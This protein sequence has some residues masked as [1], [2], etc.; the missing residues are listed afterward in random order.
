MSYAYRHFDE[1]DLPVL[2]EMG[3]KFFEQ[4]GLPGSFNPRAFEDF[5]MRTSGGDTGL[6]LLM[7]D[8]E[9]AVG[10]IGGLLYSDPCTGETSAQE[11]FW[12]VDEDH[13]GEASSGLITLFEQVAKERGAVRVLM[14][15][16]YGMKHRALKRFYEGRG[17]RPLEFSFVKEV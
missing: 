11:T 6:V 10:T 17:Y 5:W 16:I 1:N 2:E 4:A 13:R 3:F 12:W 7:L 14:N 8:G 15:S 9:S